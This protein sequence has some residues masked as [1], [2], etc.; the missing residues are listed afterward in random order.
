MQK[1]EYLR[2]SRIRK[3]DWM[4][5][6]GTWDCE[7]D[8]ND[9]GQQGWELTTIVPYCDAVANNGPTNREIWYFKR[10]IGPS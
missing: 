1:W 6:V 10:P 9:L 3:L 7:I 8:E 2:L 5:T 4:N